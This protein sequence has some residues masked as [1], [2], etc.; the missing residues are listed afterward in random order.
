M[1]GNM[2]HFHSL[3]KVS[4]WQPQSYG[5]ALQPIHYILIAYVFTT[6]LETRV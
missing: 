3:K 5:F 6:Y 4:G 1:C 2:L